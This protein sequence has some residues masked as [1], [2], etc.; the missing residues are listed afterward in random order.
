MI[1]YLGSFSIGGVFP[2]MVGAIASVKPRLT[3]ALTGA[4]KLSGLIAV[5]PPTAAF[6]VAAAQRIAAKFAL[7]P[8]SVSIKLAAQAQAIASLKAQLAIYEALF[9]AF[10]VAGV[11]AFVYHGAASKFGSEAQAAIGGGLPNGG[12]PGEVIDAIV[13]ATRYPATFT[14]LGQ[15]MIQ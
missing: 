11:D 4:L 13:L 8:P 6:G 9:A 10:G 3:S 2:T 1:S 15:V 12:V 7:Q 14:A 5:K